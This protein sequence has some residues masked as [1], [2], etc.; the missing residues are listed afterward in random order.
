MKAKTANKF[1]PEVRARAVRMVLDHEYYRT[2]GQARF[3]EADLLEGQRRH[4]ASRVG[5]PSRRLET[6]NMAVR[7]LC[8]LSRQWSRPKRSSHACDQVRIWACGC[9]RLTLRQATRG[10]QP[11]S[12]RPCWPADRSF[13][14]V[15]LIAA[16]TISPVIAATTGWTAQRP[17]EGECAIRCIAYF[18]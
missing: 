14:R 13:G 7:P 16:V 15:R 1:S 6:D 9:S 5:T 18:M 11:V 17:T 4:V 10:M 8:P 12:L 2:G 3:A